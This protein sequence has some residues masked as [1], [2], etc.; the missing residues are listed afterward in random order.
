MSFYCLWVFYF[1][2][3]IAVDLVTEDLEASAF[4]DAPSA[5][6]DVEIQSSASLLNSDNLAE[7]P[8]A[9]ASVLDDSSPE[10]STYGN[11]R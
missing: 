5:D 1:F 2:A 8:I 6:N 10:N 3:I 9:D 7:I 4:L 11:P